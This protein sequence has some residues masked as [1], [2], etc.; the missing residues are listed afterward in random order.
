MPASQASRRRAG[1]L[2][3]LLPLLFLVL[4]VGHLLRRPRSGDPAP[5]PETSDPEAH[6]EAWRGE[7]VG[8]RTSW[9]QATLTPLHPD[10][11]RNAFESRALERRLGLGA[12]R[13]WRLHVL[14]GATEAVDG[15]RAG[16]PGALGPRGPGGA[17][18]LGRTAPAGIE[19]GAVEVVDGQGVAQRS[20]PAPEAGEGPT[21]PLRVLVGPPAGALRPG[22]AADWILWGR[23]PSEGAR[24]VGLVPEDDATF[25][26]ATGLGGVLEL[27]AVSVRRGD[28]TEPLARLDR[29][30]LE[31]RKSPTS[32]SSEGTRPPADER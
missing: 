9:L 6:V 22:Q 10:P 19:L 26:A 17:E 4:A 28:L 5:P 23:E 3:F 18:P 29:P 21:D 1:T 20:L 16:R 25:R 13:A 30:P 8:A 12:G 31:P 24:L 2:L 32:P 14:W 11:E 27:R 7:L 15:A